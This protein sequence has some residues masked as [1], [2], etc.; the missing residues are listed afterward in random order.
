VASSWF[1]LYSISISSWTVIIYNWGRTIILSRLP[2]YLNGIPALFPCGPIHLNLPYFQFFHQILRGGIVSKVVKQCLI[3]YV[4]V[5]KI[6]V[7]G[8]FNMYNVLEWCQWHTDFLSGECVS[9]SHI[10][11]DQS[12]VQ[13]FFW[14]Q[15]FHKTLKENIHFK[16][17][18]ELQWRGCTLPLLCLHSCQPHVVGNIL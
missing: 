6:V 13:N 12:S 3:H 1:S 8:I 16:F 7:S 14:I 4:I 11:C 17:R 5:L 10:F 9:L 2:S 18:Q 15:V